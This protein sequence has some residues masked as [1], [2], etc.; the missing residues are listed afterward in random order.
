LVELRAHPVMA[1]AEE[2]ANKWGDKAIS[3]IES[4]PA[5]SVKSAL[6]S[7]ARAMVNRKG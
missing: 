6:E 2:F 3:A 7:F 4:L 5:G 1:E